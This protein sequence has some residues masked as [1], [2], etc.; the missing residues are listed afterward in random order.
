MTALAALPVQQAATVRPTRVGPLNVA[1][2][3]NFEAV[4]SQ[5]VGQVA[6]ADC[7][8]CGNSNGPWTLCVVVPG[9][10]GGSCANCRSVRAISD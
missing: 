10:F 1:R 9:H 4:L 2:A 6:G 5:V 8:H 7:H 3:T